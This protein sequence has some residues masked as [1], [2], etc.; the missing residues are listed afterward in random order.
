MKIEVEFDEKRLGESAAA[1]L[2]NS[3]WIDEAIRAALRPAAEKAIREL[4]PTE[5]VRAFI[6]K[7]IETVIGDVV[8]NQLRHIVKLA[9]DKELAAARERFSLPQ[10]DTPPAPAPPAEPERP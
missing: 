3:H 4:D 9:V 7:R 2:R 8:T 10:A 5:L 1:M 6:E